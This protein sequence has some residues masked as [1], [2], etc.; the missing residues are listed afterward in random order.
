MRLKQFILLFSAKAT[1]QLSLILGT[2][3]NIFELTRILGE[4][5]NIYSSH[6]K[7]KGTY[8]Q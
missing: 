6:K 8:L 2:E 5:N 4:P 7:M 1:D 3:Y